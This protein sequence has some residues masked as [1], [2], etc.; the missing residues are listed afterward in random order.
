MRIEADIKISFASQKEKERI[1][2]LFMD[3]KGQIDPVLTSAI[4]PE[5]IR[6]TSNLEIIQDRFGFYGM[7]FN[8]EDYS[9]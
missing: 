8:I 4:F 3:A 1:E 7:E 9:S 5:K 6:I 2:Q